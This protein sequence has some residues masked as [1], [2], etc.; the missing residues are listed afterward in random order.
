LVDLSAKERSLLAPFGWSI[1]SGQEPIVLDSS[2]VGN[3]L[4]F[5]IEGS[6]CADWQNGGSE[7]LSTFQAG[8]L[9]GRAFFNCDQPSLQIMPASVCMLLTQESLDHMVREQPKLAAKLYRGFAVA[10]VKHVLRYQP[11][12]ETQAAVAP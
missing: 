6:V 2:A 7:R 10:L 12:P 4:L 1:S 11:C 9:I 8:Q 3:D 5:V